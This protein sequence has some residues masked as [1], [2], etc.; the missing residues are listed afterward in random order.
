MRGELEPFGHPPIGGANRNGESRKVPGPMGGRTARDHPHQR[1]DLRGWQRTPRDNGVPMDGKGPAASL[2]RIAVGAEKAHASGIATCRCF[3]VAMGNN[4]GG[5]AAV[6]AASGLDLNAQV[7]KLQGVG[8]V[9]AA[10]FHA[11]TLSCHAS[12]H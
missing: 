12:P 11:G 4:R 10:E 8:L 2:V 1:Q 3:Q 5:M 6:R 9:T 7:Q